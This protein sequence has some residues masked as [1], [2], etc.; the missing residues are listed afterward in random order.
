MNNK[1]KQLYKHIDL[2]EE[3]EGIDENHTFEA[4][5]NAYSATAVFPADV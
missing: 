3:I 4:R 2:I 1:L 5:A